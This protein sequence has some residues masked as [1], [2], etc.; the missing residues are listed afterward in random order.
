MGEVRG[1]DGP[2]WGQVE[3]LMAV[4]SH[5]LRSPLS[6]LSVGVEALAEPGLDTDTRDR[7]LA[8]MRRAITRAERVLSDLVDVSRIAAGTLEVEPEQ[9]SIAP[10]LARAASDHET[11]ARESGT[12]I[13]V[14]AAEGLPAVNAD[15]DRVLQVLDKLI[16]NAMRHA[17][18]SGAI[19]LRAEMQHGSDGDT[20]RLWVIDGGPGIPETEIEEIFDKCWRG[21]GAR[22]RGAGIGLALAKGIAEAH[23]GSIHVESHPGA[24]ARFCV[25]L[26]VAR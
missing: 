17:R 4:M 12:W 19:T 16:T 22:P 10:L 25:E 5:D 8:A 23:G 24:G 18:G 2:A 3:R 1:G 15:A 9:V 21:H 20:V 14:D 13:V 26:P 6:A 7:Y 11:Q